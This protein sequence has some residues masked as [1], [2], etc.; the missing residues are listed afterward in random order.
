MLY[1]LALNKKEGGGYMCGVF[2]FIGK[3]SKKTNLILQ[4][5]A[6]WNMERGTDSTGFAFISGKSQAIY[7][8]STNAFDMYKRYQTKKLFSMY[9]QKDFMIMLGHTR[10][11]THGQVVANNAHPFKIG[12][13][14][15]TH[16]GIISN[17]RELQQKC[18]TNFKVDSQIIGYLIDVVG[19][20][21]TA[22]EISG[23]YVV[24]FVEQDEIDTLQVI[25]HNNPFAFAYKKGQMYYS[26][27]ML[28]LKAAL[29]EQEGFTFVQAK[30]DNLYKFYQLQWSDQII[31]TKQSIDPKVT[32]YHYGGK[33]PDNKL[34]GYRPDPYMDMYGEY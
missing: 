20:E 28:H 26:S 24:P 33:D 22:K 18:K 8:K 14:V 32:V 15:M 27:T 1:T 13:T 25:V 11:A 9:S 16:N 3:P 7:K 4:K 30:D 17:F 2:G 10:M 23:S 29:A 21:Y 34:L 5:L 6:Y 31:F 12:K 19:A